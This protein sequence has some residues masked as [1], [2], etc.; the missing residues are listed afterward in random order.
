[1]QTGGGNIAGREEEVR[2][3]MTGHTTHPGPSPLSS[4]V[5]ALG[6]GS[7][8]IADPAEA[9]PVASSSAIT[10]TFGPAVDQYAMPMGMGMI[11]DGQRETQGQAIEPAVQYV[12]KIKQRCDAETYKQFLEILSRYHQRPESIDEVRFFLF[13]LAIYYRV[14]NL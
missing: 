12:Q 7:I 6:P 4:G 13:G 5:L 1:M 14:A 3:S 10:S 11:V 9:P 2:W 8:G